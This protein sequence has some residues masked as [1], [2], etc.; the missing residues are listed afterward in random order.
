MKKL[1]EG[2]FG[3]VYQVKDKKNNFYALKKVSKKNFE[4]KEVKEGKK[5]RKFFFVI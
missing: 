4:E 5:L 3:V 1:G 2:K